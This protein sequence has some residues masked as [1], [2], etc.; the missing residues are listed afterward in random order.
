MR[1]FTNIDLHGNNLL[2][3]EWDGSSHKQ[4]KVAFEPTLY[5]PTKADS[6]IKTHTGSHSLQPRRFDSIRAAREFVDRY[7]DTIQLFGTTNYVAQF[8]AEHYD[9][10]IEYD[11]AHIRVFNFD[12]E[13]FSEDGFPH[14]DLAE[15]PIVSIALYDSL[16]DQFYVW[17]LAADNNEQRQW[18]SGENTPADIHVNYMQ[19]RTESALLREFVSFWHDNCPHVITGWNI[20][21]FDVPYIIN[22]ITNILGES[23][24]KLISP[25][26]IVR[27]RKFYDSFGQQIETYTVVGV[28]TLD[29]LELYLK[30]TYNS[31]ESYALDHIAHL[32]LGEKKLSYEEA[33]SLHR[34]YQTDFQRFIDY[35]IRDVWLVKK[36][37]EKMQLLEL[38]FSLSYY[39][40][41]PFNDTFS[42]VKTWETLIYHYL[43]ERRMYAP[44]KKTDGKDREK[45]PGA[46]VMQPKTNGKIVKWIVSV[47]LA[48][49]YPHLIM[50]YNIGP[51]TLV[52]TGSLPAELEQFQSALPQSYENKIAAFVDRQVDTEI[53]KRY[54]VC[55]AAN[56]QLFRRDHRSYVSA[57][58]KDLYNERKK[59]K[60]EM[61]DAQQAVQ[62]FEQSGIDDPAEYRRLT[63]KVVQL[64]NGQLARKIVLNSGYG[65]FSNVYFQF[66]DIRLASAITTSGQLSNRWIA[67]HLNAFLNRL[68]K[69]DGVDYVIYGDT[70]SDYL[71]LE[72]I[73]ELHPQAKDLT[74]EQTVDFLDKF[75]SEILEPEIARG[76]NQLGE[77]MNVFEQA[78]K[79][80]REAI[81]STGFWTAKKRYALLVHDNE[82]VRYATPKMKI[83]GLEIVKS[84]TPQW[85]RD[86]L[87]EA[88][89][90]MLTE[91]EEAVQQFVRDVRSYFMSLPV[92]D[93]AVPTGCSNVNK[94]KGSGNNIY[95]KGTPR[96]SKAALVYNTM[97]EKHHLT[98]L[99]AI[100]DGS[101]IKILKLL[102]PNPTGDDVIAFPANQFLPKQFNLHDYVDRESLFK[103]GFL[104]PL[105]KMLEAVGWTAEKKSTIGWLFG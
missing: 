58:M 2:V 32:Q 78:M 16:T 50:Q 69:T 80:D 97:L 67:R 14:A 63:N 39:T 28:S 75:C 72:K 30:Y 105:E 55:V 84:S 68:C 94:W 71:C 92:E 42:P 76:F 56:G 13:V 91:G 90:L 83:M 64:N 26:K 5:I 20:T 81:A 65:A 24:A 46:F 10:H 45:F 93:I 53:L 36:I 23:Y 17:A 66:F 4:Y 37:D 48:S 100:T 41:Q 7:S 15:A 61:L 82:G 38:I 89:R 99:P 98:H 44:L 29:Y 31:E 19:F 25:W 88:V 102:K 95:I 73:V 33:G 47:D 87:R 86:K 40:K 49:L 70:D 51:D 59:I 11:S 74:L 52:P 12:I 1:F 22:R 101:K 104:S 57:I 96:Q 85:A 79:M 6:E 3:R 34:L 27:E 60:K 9:R 18:N 103:A 35:N 62:R 21:K 43:R 54:N 8:V 77:Y